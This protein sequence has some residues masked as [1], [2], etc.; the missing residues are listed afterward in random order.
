MPCLSGLTFGS[1]V[2]SRQGGSALV[3]ELWVRCPCPI[4]RRTRKARLVCA[5]W[6]MVVVVG[7]ACDSLGKP[8]SILGYLKAGPSPIAKVEG[9]TFRVFCG[10]PTGWLWDT[11]GWKDPCPPQ[12]KAAT[13]RHLCSLRGLFRPPSYRGGN[14]GSGGWGTSEDP[15]SIKSWPCPQ[16]GWEAQ[17]WRLSPLHFIARSC[18][19]I[20]HPAL[21]LTLLLWRV[22]GP[23]E[24]CVLP[25]RR[26]SPGP[27]GRSREPSFTYPQT[28]RGPPTSRVP[29]PNHWCTPPSF[30]QEV[31]CSG[32]GAS[33]YL[34]V[35]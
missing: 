17:V 27:L 34:W 16:A 10:V 6:I 8:K 20:S 13:A 5:E 26:D 14:W 28:L 23:F 2:P 3:P 33:W 24:L 29:D 4:L 11:E 7:W 35:T 21:G 25:S 32:V 22:W 15:P 1:E 9:A 18:W 31:G 12:A 30:W 19:I